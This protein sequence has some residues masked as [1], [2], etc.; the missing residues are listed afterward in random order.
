[1]RKLPQ[2]PSTLW[3]IGVISHS[4]LSSL[5]P[6]STPTPLKKQLWLGVEE[7]WPNAYLSTKPW[8]PILGKLKTRMPLWAKRKIISN[9]GYFGPTSTTPHTTPSNR[10]SFASL[11]C[12]LHDDVM[13][14]THH[15]S[16]TSFEARL[17]NSS[18]TCSPTKQ[19]TGC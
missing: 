8:D 17:G 15:R 11:P 1:V 3:R 19:A 10:P 18:L 16:F 12:D 2:H 4:L 9:E 13:C 5:T 14:T 7:G 6:S